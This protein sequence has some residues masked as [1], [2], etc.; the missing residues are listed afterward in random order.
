MSAASDNDG[1]PGHA[2]S[3]RFGHAP[4]GE[5]RL[6]PSQRGGWNGDRQSARDGN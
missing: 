5:F 1:A 3:E 6:G 2:G 4:A